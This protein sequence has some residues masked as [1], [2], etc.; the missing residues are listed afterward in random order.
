MVQWRFDEFLRLTHQ[1]DIVVQ[2]KNY[3]A[4]RH[5]EEESVARFCRIVFAGGAGV[6]FHRP[7]PR[8]DPDAHEA[9]S[10][11]GLGLSP[12]AQSIIASM[13]EIGNAMEFVRTKPRNDLLSD[14]SANEAYCLAEPGRQYAL[15]F[16][17]GGEVK[18]DVSAVPGS[19]EVRWLDINRSRWQEPETVPG[20]GTLESQAPA[21]GH[22]GVVILPR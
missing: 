20:G 3:G 2:N 11:F 15:Y 6:R 16:P 19:L 9:A 17:D 18:L 12:R 13:R 5:G 22:W 14:R 1:R 10:D 21:K 7:H 4:A 8:E